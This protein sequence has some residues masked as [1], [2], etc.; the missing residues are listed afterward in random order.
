MGGLVRVCV[1]VGG[2][3]GINGKIGLLMSV[4]ACGASSAVVEVF[5][6]ERVRSLLLYSNELELIGADDAK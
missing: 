2:T 6:E 3:S 1:D 5:I 4:T